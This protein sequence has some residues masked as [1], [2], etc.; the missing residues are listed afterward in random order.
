MDKTFRRSDGFEPPDLFRY[1]WDHL[2]CAEILFASGPLASDSAGYLS[3]LGIELMLKAILLQVTGEFPASHSLRR[4]HTSVHEA[5]PAF[6]LGKSHL[7]LLEGIDRLCELRYPNRQNPVEVGHEEYYQVSSLA[8]EIHR[9][10]PK[11]LGD[12]FHQVDILEKGGRRLGY[13]LTEKDP[14]IE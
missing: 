3:H 4:L 7:Q 5:V 8:N 9:L 10:I 13:L 2:R 1:G 14:R 6:V 11:E 12:A